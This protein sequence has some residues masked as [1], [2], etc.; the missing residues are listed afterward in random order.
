[1]HPLCHLFPRHG[2]K[3]EF[4]AKQAN[5]SEFSVE[6]RLGLLWK[7]NWRLV[8]VETVFF[9]IFRHSLQMP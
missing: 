4:H 3:F 6:M 2:L 8:A 5:G 9:D 7:H 1:M